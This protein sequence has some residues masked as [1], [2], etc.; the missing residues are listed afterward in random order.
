MS[1]LSLIYLRSQPKEI[2]QAHS[3]HNI[4]S[5]NY[6][7]NDI[8]PLALASELKGN[9]WRGIFRNEEFPTFLSTEGGGAIAYALT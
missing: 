9:S 7:L 6:G 4:V 3:G 8:T 2:V 1:E 5:E